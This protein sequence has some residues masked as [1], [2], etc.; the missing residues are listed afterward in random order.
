MS[1][2]L[3]VNLPAATATSSSH[4]QTMRDDPYKQT[5]ESAPTPAPATKS[6]GSAKT[7]PKDHR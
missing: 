4:W 6:A 7:E 5:R 2:T 3:P 1:L